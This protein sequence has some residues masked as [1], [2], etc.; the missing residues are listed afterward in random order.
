MWLVEGCAALFEHL[1]I[2][3]HHPELKRDGIRQAFEACCEPHRFLPE[4]VRE[5]LQSPFGAHREDKPG[6][7][8]AS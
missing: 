2:R 6:T 3:E 8:C 4:G 1:Y 5:E 7:M